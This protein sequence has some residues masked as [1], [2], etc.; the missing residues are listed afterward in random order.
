MHAHTSNSRYGRL[1]AVVAAAVA[2]LA[3]V[4]A[5]APPAAAAST[6]YSLTQTIPVPPAS[7]YAGVGGGDGWDLSFTSD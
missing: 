4:I 5:T 7:N 3:G 1:V 6:V 2:A